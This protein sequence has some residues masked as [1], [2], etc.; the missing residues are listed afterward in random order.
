MHSLGNIKRGRINGF[1]N[2]LPIQLWAYSEQVSPT[3]D[4]LRYMGE[5][6]DVRGVI[7]DGIVPGEELTVGSNTW[8]CFPVVEKVESGGT[9]Y[10][11]VAYRKELS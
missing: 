1:I 7:L 10:R 5:H 8:V 2:L 9:R 11:G 4:R 3:P 6:P